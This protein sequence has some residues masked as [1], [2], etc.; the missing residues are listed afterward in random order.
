MQ[1]DKNTTKEKA[2]LEN[3]VGS[4]TE[5]LETTI[6]LADKNPAKILSVSACFFVDSTEVLLGEVNYSGTLTS[7]LLY[8]K[9]DGT[10]DNLQAS[11]SI[12]GKF[13]NGLFVVDGAIRVVPNI[14]SNDLEKVNGDTAKLKTNIELSFYQLQN[15]ELDVYSGGEEDIF[16]KQSEIPLSNF[17]NKNCFTFTQPIILDC[18]SKLEKIL[19]V[20][21]GAIVKKAT[22]LDS[23]VVLEGDVFAN[24]LAT[25]DGEPNKFVALSN[26]ESFREEVEDG[27]A[28]KDSLIEAYAR[29]ICENVETNF[30][31][32]NLGI[33]IQV[34]VKACYELF[35]NKNITVVTD[36]YAIKNELT[37]STTGFNSTEFL[38][39]E[40]FE[41]KIDGNVSLDENLPRIDKVL[42]VDGAYLTLTNVAYEDRELLVEGIARATVIYLNDDEN[43]INSVVV[44]IPFSQT[45]RT[46]L[47]EHDVNVKLQTIFYNVDATAKRGRELFVDGKVKLVAWFNKSVANA[48][49]SN[50]ERGE[51][52][53]ANNAA[54][55]IYYAAHG[56]TLWDVAKDLRV[57][58]NVLKNQN[59]NLTEPFIN[60]EKIVY[61]NQKTAQID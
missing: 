25:I 47:D 10:V 26:I 19:S 11:T 41:F 5:W 17:T 39:N 22:V 1:N 60:E 50:I 24:T 31:E 58:E 57:S 30:L 52:V 33:E 23:V 59:P 43:T 2:V 27:T 3:L 35:E 54:I 14:I 53:Q 12:N 44:E 42:A 29:V 18:K 7:N 32:E 21:T 28:K 49:I 8:Q 48:I 55:E 40:N 38:G 61:Y 51:E 46:T 36:A 16:V 13:E 45:E 37:I 6:N 15:Q 9:E 20:S 34:P 4:K 56:Q